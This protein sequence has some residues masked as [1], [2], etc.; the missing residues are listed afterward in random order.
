MRNYPKKQ[1]QYNQ[2]KMEW[3]FLKG[4]RQVLSKQYSYVIVA[5]RGFGNDR[6]FNYCEEIGFEYIIRITPNMNIEMADNV[7]IC[8]KKLVDDGIYDVRVPKWE[9]NIRL[10]RHSKGDKTWYLVS[11]MKDISEVEMS[12]TY[13]ER[14]K[15]EKCFQD[16]KSS[17]FD[18]ESSKI[19]K[20]SNYKRMLLICM[21]AHALMEILGNFIAV[22]LPAFLKN[23]A[24][25]ED[26]ILAYLQLEE[27]QCLFFLKKQA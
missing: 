12:R 24:L 27:R 20:Y 19:R 26:A 11:N 16:M 18:M 7:D 22:K 1:G 21:T 14:F 4:L 9:K 17:G 5:D 3:A 6:I 10:C 23:F 15:I 8:S 13:A 25:I 2:K